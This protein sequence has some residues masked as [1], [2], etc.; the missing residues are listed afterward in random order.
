[1][2]FLFREVLDWSIH[3]LPILGA[4]VASVK[5]TAS[6][7]ASSPR[8]Q[9]RHRVPDRNRNQTKEWVRPRPWTF[10]V[11]LDIQWLLRCESFWEKS[12]GIKDKLQGSLMLC[13]VVNNTMST[14]SLVVVF[15]VC[16]VWTTELQLYTG[17]RKY[18]PICSACPGSL[19]W[20]ERV[21]LKSNNNL[22]TAN[23]S[24]TFYLAHNTNRVVTDNKPSHLCFSHFWMWDRHKRATISVQRDHVHAIT[25]RLHWTCF[26]HFSSD[27]A[28]MLPF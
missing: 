12:T 1:M 15:F 9:I 25:P 8:P 26:G 6:V 2:R 24:L 18:V 23:G 14:N 7:L 3:Q 10:S 20:E 22:K 17:K 28:H 21:F 13:Y 5:H 4:A 11:I 19:L 27:R 16:F